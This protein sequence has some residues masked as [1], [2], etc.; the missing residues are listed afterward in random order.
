ME[1]MCHQEN[2]DCVDELKYNVNNV[3][4][5]KSVVKANFITFLILCNK[6]NM[7]SNNN[8]NFATNVKLQVTEDLQVTFDEYWISCN[9]YGYI[10]INYTYAGEYGAFMLHWCNKIY[11]YLTIR[12]I[13]EDDINGK[14][15]VT[16]EYFT[17]SIKQGTF[18]KNHAYPLFNYIKVQIEE[19]GFYMTEL[20]KGYYVCERNT[21]T[22]LAKK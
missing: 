21:V 5:L 14:D 7:V 18:I 4:S 9:Y 19:K 16:I 11:D 15:H 10:F 1:V 6:C 13:Y 20:R 2:H 17:N 22:K 3:N 8:E 12:S